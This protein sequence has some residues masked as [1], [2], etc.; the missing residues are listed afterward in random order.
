MTLFPT[1]IIL[2]RRA[3][4]GLIAAFLAFLWL[5][6]ADKFLHMDHSPSPN[7]NRMPVAFPA[8]QPSI[9]E[10]GEFLTGVEAWF[11]DSFGFRRQ[12]VRW[13]QHWKWLI[14]RDVRVANAMAG[15][16]GWLYYSDGRMIDDIR[17]TRPFSD[18][19]L[20]RWRALLTGRR[21]WLRQRGIRYLFVVPP[22]KHEIYPEHLPDWLHSREGTP[23]RLDQFLAH[24]RAHSDVPILDLRDA[25]LSAK[26]RGMT[27]LR[28]DSHWNDRGAFAAYRRIVE[29]LAS[30]GIPAV[31][32]GPDSFHE[33]LK[34]APGGD[35]AL[36]LGQQDRMVETGKPTLAPLP[37]LLPLDVRTE[38]R[39][40]AR[41][42]TPG[43]EPLVSDNPRATGKVVMFRDSY[44]I[45]LMKFFGYSFQRVVY[46]WQQNWDKTLIEQEHPDV[47]IDEMLERFLI[48]RN[49][50][51]LKKKDEQP[52]AEVLAED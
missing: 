41:K 2:R 29:E 36:L 19:E 10:M 27:Y 45:T 40:G 22:D 23:R 28:S 17:G 3:D 44:A 30:L 52:D 49:P 6:T 16:D 48:T 12:L 7:E 47:V 18:T 11:K 38:V 42:R 34:D 4:I 32:P 31:A 9:S 50:D 39:P 21:D 15:K 1:R 43:S 8:F 20:E 46:V 24:M 26:Q 14:F 35:L 37:P 51:D 33:T 25:L 13:A 5:P